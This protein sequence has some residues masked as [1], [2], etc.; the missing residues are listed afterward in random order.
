MIYYALAVTA[1]AAAELGALL[2][3]LSAVK[4]EKSPKA[5]K[6]RPIKVLDDNKNFINYNGSEQL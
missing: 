5:K 4:R 6:Y 3:I 1:L 2:G